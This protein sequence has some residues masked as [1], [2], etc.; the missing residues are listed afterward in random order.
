MVE[1]EREFRE[2]SKNQ[3]GEILKLNLEKELHHQI[4]IIELRYTRWTKSLLEIPVQ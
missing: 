4:K 3:K 2:W 1:A